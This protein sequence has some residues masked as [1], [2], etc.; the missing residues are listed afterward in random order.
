VAGTVLGK[1]DRFEAG[2][3]IAIRADVP[4]G[5]SAAFLFA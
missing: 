4:K 1:Y 2:V 3:I 5:L